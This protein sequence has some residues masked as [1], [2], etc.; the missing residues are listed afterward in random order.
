MYQNV[1]TSCHPSCFKDSVTKKGE[2]MLCLRIGKFLIRSRSSPNRFIMNLELDP[3]VRKIGAVDIFV[4]NLDNKLDNSLLEKHSA[5]IIHC[6]C[7]LL[8]AEM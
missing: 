5:L 8:N 7:M 1:S 3:N 4:K 6:L 2:K